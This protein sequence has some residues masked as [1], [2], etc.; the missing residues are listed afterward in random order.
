MGDPFDYNP[1][2]KTKSSREASKIQQKLEVPILSNR[3][4]GERFG[5]LTP[6]SSQVCAGGE[7]GKDSCKGDSGGGLFLQSSDKDPWYLLG[8]VSLGSKRCGSG[9]PAVYTRI[10]SFLPWLA[11]NLK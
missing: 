3:E 7:Q 1:L 4:C 2:Q 9:S 8:L 6:V 5:F 11:E 10:F